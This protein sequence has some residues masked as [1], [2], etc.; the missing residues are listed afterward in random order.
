[1]TS[2]VLASRSAVR[3]QILRNAGVLFS[4]QPAQIDESAVKKKMSG[5]G[6]RAIAER[7]AELK[8]LQIST[9]HPQDLALG[10]DQVLELDGEVFSKAETLDAAAI[11]LRRLRGKKHQLIGALVMARNG[12]A[13]WRRTEVSTLW[14]R[15]FSDAFLGN[16]L[17]AEGDTLLGSVG[18][19]RY[20]GLGAQLFERVE[21][22]YFSILG[23]SLLP[24]LAALRDQGVIAQ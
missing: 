18:C 21:G 13:L 2:L 17:G 8:A 20:E 23:L 9:K 10:A 22:D 12:S 14:V 3:A 4:V 6:G 15:D 24:L 1:M 16:Y 19:Y 7:L 11:Q 5:A